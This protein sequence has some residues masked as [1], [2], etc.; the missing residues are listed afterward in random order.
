[1]YF[2]TNSTPA[3]LTRELTFSHQTGAR[4][5]AKTLFVG[6]QIKVRYNE[7]EG[8]F[9]ATAVLDGQPMVRKDIPVSAFQF[10]N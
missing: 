10:N 1:M 4:S 2:P 3:T 7:R 5:R 9:D 8:R 6:S